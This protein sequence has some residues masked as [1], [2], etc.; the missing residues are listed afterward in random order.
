MAVTLELENDEFATLFFY[1]QYNEKNLEDPIIDKLLNKMETQI[2]S[3]FSIDEVEKYKE[4]ILNKMP[5][6]EKT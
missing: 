5:M 4:N 6:G 2:Y 3:R 1:L